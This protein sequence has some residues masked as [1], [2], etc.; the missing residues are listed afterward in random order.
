MA[1]AFSS[2]LLVAV[3]QAAALAAFASA[4]LLL[5]ALL[6]LRAARRA[7]E[8]RAALRTAAW[9]DAL[10]TAIYAPAQAELP[11]VE[12]QCLPDF[13]HLWNR[14]R[15]SV[16]GEAG[17]NLA[18]LLRGN[19]MVA[20]IR[21]LAAE[22]TLGQRLS[23]ITTIGHLRDSAWWDNLL[24]LTSAAD[25]VLSFAALRALFR[26]DPARALDL[27]LGQA[28][29][30]EEWPLAGLGATLQEIGPDLVTPPMVRLLTSPR[31]R[32]WNAC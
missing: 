31:T 29:R 32:A 8:R 24:A 18:E 26:I 2:S 5:A 21:A 12:P 27:L 11:P 4:A 16:R 30:R 7:R 15:E 25:A 13:L 20:R 22:G 28:A 6:W 1:L 19:D 14:L 10:H 23:A 9:R 17:E 3:T